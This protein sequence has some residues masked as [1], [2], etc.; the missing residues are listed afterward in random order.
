MYWPFLQVLCME[1]TTQYCQFQNQPIV[2]LDVLWQPKWWALKRLNISIQQ[3]FR[4]LKIFVPHGENIHF[5]T[6]LK[7]TKHHQGSDDNLIDQACR[8]LCFYVNCDTLPQKSLSISNFSLIFQVTRLA[9]SISWVWVFGDRG[10]SAH[11][12][13]EQFD[14]L[15]HAFSSVPGSDPYQKYVPTE[16]HFCS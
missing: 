7:V 11:Q 6:L 16:I 13:F 2:F 15:V 1:K 12:M 14:I 3:W 5:Y 9:F 8:S 4:S 10:S